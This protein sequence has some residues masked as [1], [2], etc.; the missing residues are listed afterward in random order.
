MIYH[1]EIIFHAFSE[2]LNGI[3]ICSIEDDDAR[4]SKLDVSFVCSIAPSELPRLSVWLP[5]AKWEIRDQSS[6]PQS[7][8]S[9]A[10]QQSPQVTKRQ[11]RQNSGP[12]R[13]ERGAQTSPIDASDP[14]LGDEQCYVCLAYTAVWVFF[15]P[16]ASS[17][18][19]KPFLCSACFWK[20]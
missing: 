17:A 18:C 4:K 10:W 2:P 7:Q 8:V 5:N 16:P 20:S 1:G 9:A 19:F 13:P 12:P 15:L 6:H 14:L 3:F 11:A